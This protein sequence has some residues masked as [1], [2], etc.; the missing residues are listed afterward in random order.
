MQNA[1]RRQA[2]ARAKQQQ[3]Q[4]EVEAAQQDAQERRHL[5]EEQK[6]LKLAGPNLS[7][8]STTSRRSSQRTASCF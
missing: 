1:E 3:R 7:F 8:A 4:R 5:L 6:L 2:E